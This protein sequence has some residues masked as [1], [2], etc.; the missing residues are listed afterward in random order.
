[1]EQAKSKFAFDPTYYN[2]VAK[3]YIAE[4][5]ARKLSDS[6]DYLFEEEDYTVKSSA[7]PA[8]APVKP[9]RTP[10]PTVTPTHKRHRR[11]EQRAD[12]TPR[13]KTR[14]LV[15][16][17]YLR[18]IAVIILIAL[19]WWTAYDLLDTKSEVNIIEKEINTAKIT[20]EDAN[21]YNE[22]LLSRLDITLDRNYI[23]NVAV[24]KLGMVYPKDNEVVYYESVGTGHVI[25]YHDLS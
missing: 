4:S 5:T 14:F 17:D 23:Y 15:R 19:V 22:S 20:L 18:T 11:P 1:M 12:E 24:G 7:V 16:I 6:L 25:Q 2:K 9:Q 10:Q 3:N 8:A 21:S 13:I